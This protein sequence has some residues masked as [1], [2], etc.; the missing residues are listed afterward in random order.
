MD[1]ITDL[2]LRA[3]SASVLDVGCNRGM[4]GFE[5][6]NNGARI[7]D[8]CD[9]DP[10]SIEVARAVFADI[11]NVRSKF[12]VVDLTEGSSALVKA[13]GREQYDIVL[14]LA[15]IHKIKRE[16]SRDD[17]VDLLHHFGTLTRKFLAWRGTQRDEA[18][19]FEEV[20]LLDGLPRLRRVQYSDISQLGPA[21]IWERVK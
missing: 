11:R 20:R 16:M 5:F 6:A 7:V 10:D 21:A 12:A 17:L 4:V 3:R 9:N 13:F 8:G 19:N 14:L 2:V 15:V 18:G 1:G